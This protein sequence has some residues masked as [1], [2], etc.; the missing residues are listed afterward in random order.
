MT[1]D[2]IGKLFGDR[3]YISH[4]KLQSDVVGYWRG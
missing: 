2:L 4:T 3:G 1:K